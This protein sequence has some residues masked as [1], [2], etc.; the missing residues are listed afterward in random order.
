MTVS[1]WRGFNDQFLAPDPPSFE[2]SSGFHPADG[3]GF[4]VAI[5]KPG[6][7]TKKGFILL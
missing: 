7:H 6:D 4:E 1:V 5:K 2:T 3:N